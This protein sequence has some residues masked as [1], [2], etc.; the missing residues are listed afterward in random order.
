VGLTPQPLGMRDLA[1]GDRLVLQNL[2]NSRYTVVVTSVGPG[3]A[4]GRRT[5]PDGE[6]FG[7]V[8]KIY[9]WQIIGRDGEPAFKHAGNLIPGDLVYCS[10][11]RSGLQYG[12]AVMSRNGA[13]RLLRWNE[14]TGTWLKRPQETYCKIEWIEHESEPG[15]LGRFFDRIKEDRSAWLD[16]PGR[17]R[18]KLNPRT[19]YY[20]WHQK[21]RRWRS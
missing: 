21:E 1:R 14:A 9:Y 17:S 7:T 18:M 16:S 5:G 6:A 15:A 8:G 11:Y 13:I 19:G 10:D 20:E 3:R 12:K 4:S 2:D